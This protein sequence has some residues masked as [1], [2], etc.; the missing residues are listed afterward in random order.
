M[1]PN[2]LDAHTEEW[3][4]ER[5]TLRISRP[6]R[7]IVRTQVVGFAPREFLAPIVQAVDAELELAPKPEIFHDWAE[8]TGY[9]SA[10]RASMTAW[11]GRVK[12]RCGSVHVFTMSKLVAM[13]VSLVALATGNSLIA[14][15]SRPPF[16]AA[17]QEA[18][19]KRRLRALR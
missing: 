9:E 6:A 4:T 19:A 16:E 1:R 3:D 7:G 17:Y 13:G 15:A 8:M 11:Y 10:S 2:R 14:H 18:L 12:D 5:G